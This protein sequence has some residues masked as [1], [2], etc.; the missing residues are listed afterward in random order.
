MRRLAARLLGLVLLASL[1]ACCIDP[2]AG[3]YASEGACYP[4]Y[5]DY[6]VGAAVDYGYGYGP[7]YASCR[8]YRTYTDRTY[9]PCRRYAPSPCPR[10]SFS[11]GVGHAGSGGGHFQGSLSHGSPSQGSHGGHR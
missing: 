3:R 10:P 11:R 2:G 1:G 7:G 8:T 5:Y 9:G 4:S 6:P